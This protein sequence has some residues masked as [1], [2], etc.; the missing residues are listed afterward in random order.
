MCAI[1]HNNLQG[2]RCISLCEPYGMV[3]VCGVSLSDLQ[4]FR[5]MYLAYVV[6][7]S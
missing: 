1:R 4:W 6:W 2:V 3:L 7:P 5:Y